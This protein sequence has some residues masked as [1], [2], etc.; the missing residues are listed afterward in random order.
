[1]KVIIGGGGS[2]E[3]EAEVLARYCGALGANAR[4]LNVPWAQQ[5]PGGASVGCVGSSVKRAR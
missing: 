5:R 1:M 3:Q 2:A 4:V